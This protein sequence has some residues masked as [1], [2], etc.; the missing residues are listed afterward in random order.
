MMEEEKIQTNYSGHPC[1]R[2]L[3]NFEKFMNSLNQTKYNNSL[4]ECKEVHCLAK[5]FW[6]ATR[7]HFIHL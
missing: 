1:H 4:L 3:I 5:K 2:Y 7:T 6:A